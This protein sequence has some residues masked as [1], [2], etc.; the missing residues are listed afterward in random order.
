M[1]NGRRRFTPFRKKL[2]AA[3]LAIVAVPAFVAIHDSARIRAAA[4]R[5]APDVIVDQPASLQFPDP[6]H[7]TLP[8]GR[9]FRLAH[10]IGPEPGTP[11]YARATW[12]IGNATRFGGNRK[13]GF[14]T[15]G[16]T[17]D[18]ETL[19]ELWGL[20]PSL[21]GCGNMSWSERRRARVPRWT[22]LSWQLLSSGCYRLR[23]GVGDK[24]LVAWEAAAR[25]DALGVW[26]DPRTIRRV[27]NLPELERRLQDLPSEGE[28]TL[29]DQRVEA[30][31]ML[32]RADPQ[33]Y[34]PLLLAVVSNP[35]EPDVFVRVRVAQ[36]MDKAGHPEGTAF[37]MEALRGSVPG[38]FGEYGEQ[39][40]AGEYQTYWNVQ[41]YSSRP[42]D[43]VLTHYDR[44]VRPVP[45]G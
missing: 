38:G 33:T 22:N 16:V 45:R 37:L 14:R 23:P 30:A 39:T 35:R 3:A 43:S 27:Y 8:D 5:N 26:G 1:R 44:K 29:R 25:R 13:Q 4:S 31:D 41:P 21:G 15:V 36:L 17:P 6:V 10:V 12:V 19:V 40:V 28:P 42:R 11:E 18:G 34:A 2:L 32:L 24:E 7:V 9:T 20:Q